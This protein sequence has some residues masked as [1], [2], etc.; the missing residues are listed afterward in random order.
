MN[1]PLKA[2]FGL[3]AVALPKS[4][5]LFNRILHKLSL[6]ALRIAGDYLIVQVSLKGFPCGEEL[7]PRSACVFP[8]KRP[9]F[10]MQT[11]NDSLPLVYRQ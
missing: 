5:S 3:R 8:C 11:H 6:N 7:Q 9:D 2:V 10:E 1:L 4:K